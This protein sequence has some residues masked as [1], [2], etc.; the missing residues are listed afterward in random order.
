MVGAAA[1]LEEE[2]AFE[3]EEEAE[4]EA[5]EAEEEAEALAELEGEQLG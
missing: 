4:A 2:E 3:A 5:F 1:L